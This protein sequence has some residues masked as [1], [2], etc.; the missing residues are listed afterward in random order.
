MNRILFE[1]FANLDE[2]F[3]FLK[4]AKIDKCKNLLLLE[5]IKDLITAK[6]I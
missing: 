4:N 6:S 2:A 5:D 3:K 1:E